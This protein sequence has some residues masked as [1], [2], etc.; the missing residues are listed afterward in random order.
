MRLTESN[1]LA[2]ILRVR[3]VATNLCRR[4][5]HSFRS[6][7][8]EIRQAMRLT[9]GKAPSP[10]RKEQLGHSDVLNRAAEI[11]PAAS[12]RRPDR[13][14]R[15]AVA[16]LHPFYFIFESNRCGFRIAEIRLKSNRSVKL[17][18]VRI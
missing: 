10:R 5:F 16:D 9:A 7:W 15:D 8:D 17:K 11:P 1:W 12:E 2:F 4:H 18:R 13:N 6:D 14:E 3:C